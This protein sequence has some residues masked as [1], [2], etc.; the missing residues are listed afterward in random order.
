[1]DFSSLSRRASPLWVLGF[2]EMTSLVNIVA[3]YRMGRGVYWL[4]PNYLA[5]KIRPPG[6]ARAAF[7]EF[8]RRL[9]DWIE[10]EFRGPSLN[11]FLLGPLQA[12]RIAGRIE[13]GKA[14]L[15]GGCLS[16][17]T[18][19]LS[20]ATGR[21]LRP[22]GRWLLVEDINEAPYRIDRCLA[23]LKLAGWFE[24]LAGVLVADFH[25]GAEDQQPAVVELL[26]YHLPRRTAPAIAVTR[27]AGHVWPMAPALMNR[28]LS[29]RVAGVRVTFEP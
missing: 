15:I 5:W 6:S 29:V 12:E 16:V 19:L 25:T 27:A 1:V 20:G 10:R 24:R 23:A 14:R 22:D 28:P 17:L 3:S 9:P 26:S 18:P 21:R 13:P 7:G 2:S 4:C 11:P 8:W